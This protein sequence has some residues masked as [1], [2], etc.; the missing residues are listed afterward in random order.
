MPRIAV[1]PDMIQW[2]RERAGLTVQALASRFPKLE[3][4]ERGEARPTLKQL[5]GLRQSDARSDRVPLPTG[6]ARGTSPDP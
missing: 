2:A 6:A 1:K 4:W 3:A 5:E